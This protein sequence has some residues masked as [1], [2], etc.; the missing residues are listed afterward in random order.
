MA[1]DSK[2]NPML[3]TA[4]KLKRMRAAF[5]LHGASGRCGFRT[6]RKGL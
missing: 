6:G 1:R 4:G 5:L 3:I 2:L